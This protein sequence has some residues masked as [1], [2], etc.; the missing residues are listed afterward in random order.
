MSLKRIDIIKERLKDKDVK[1]ISNIKESGKGLVV[2]YG[3]G[4]STYYRWANFTD[5]N[6]INDII[7]NSKGLGKPFTP[8]R[9]R[10]E[11][12]KALSAKGYGGYFGPIDAITGDYTIIK[13]STGEKIKYKINFDLIKNQKQLDKE[14]KDIITAFEFGYAFP[15]YD[16]IYVE[17]TRVPMSAY[18]SYFDLAY[19]KVWDAEEKRHYYIYYYRKAGN[20]A[21]IYLRMDEVDGH[22]IEI[23]E[24]IKATMKGKYNISSYRGRNGEFL[25][26][27]D[28]GESAASIL[29]EKDAVE[30]LFG[31]KP[32][33]AF[34]NNGIVIKRANN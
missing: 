15:N 18:T 1:G 22:E 34:V 28:I 26:Q 13:K 19:I 23:A 31:K 20:G 6:I 17:V 2:N 3:S 9:A 7:A 5:D 16:E 24:K 27:S 30:A 11:L 14:V 4:V 21:R 32:M 29:Y 8:Q 12:I 25:V 33:V 10:M